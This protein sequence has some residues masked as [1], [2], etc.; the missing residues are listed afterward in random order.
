MG[1]PLVC[2]LL[3]KDTWVQIGILINFDENCKKPYVFSQVSP[4]VFWIQGVT[5]PSHAP[6]F[7]QRPV[8]TSNSSNYSVSTTANASATTSAYIHPHFISL[9]Q[10]QSK[11]Q[12]K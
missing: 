3:Q 5:N 8:T 6:W 11:T 2:K 4:F 7:Q 12:S 1:A 10:P 9:P